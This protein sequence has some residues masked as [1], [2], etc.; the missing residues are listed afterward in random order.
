LA[1]HETT[2]LSR[3][4]LL[5]SAVTA[6]AVLGGAGL[7]AACG[8]S[9]APA[10]V[11]TTAATTAPVAAAATKPATVATTA[12]TGAQAAPTTASAAGATVAPTTG[13]SAAAAPATTAGTTAPTPLPPPAGKKAVMLRLHAR[14]GVEDQ[15]L[16]K[17]LALFQQA[18]PGVGVT[19]ET[20]AGGEYFQKLQ[21]LAAGGNLGDVAHLFT[22]D[23][24]YQQFFL[25]GIFIPIDDYIN[26]EKFDLNQYYKYSLDSARVDGKLGGLPFKSHPS[27]VGLFYN[28]DLFAQAGL[29]PPTLDM[30]LDEL[31]DAA[32]KMTK[33]GDASTATYGYG[34]LWHDIEYYE[35]I[36]RQFGGD[37]F[38]TDGKKWTG[39]SP[40]AAKAWQQQYDLMN[41]YKVSVNPLQSNPSN[42]DLFLSG[43]LGM[44]RANIGTKAGFTKIDKFK[45]NM[46]LPPK[47]PTGSRGS[48]AETDMMSITKFSKARDESWALL[49]AITSKDAGL[50]LA[51]QTGNR[52]ST[53]GGRPDVY[54]SPEF[55]N[56]PGY[57]KGVQENT[58]LA[59]E[60]VEPYRAPDN[61]R[62]PELGRIVDPILDLLILG[63]EQPNK[64]FLD[65]LGAEAQSVMD[66][67]R[68]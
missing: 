3:R 56:L 41:T 58:K 20:F 68:A 66:K 11:P 6:A 33:A 47:G 57:P 10:A 39:S 17:Q 21:T 63:K 35:C 49:K 40:E 27:R 5:R 9:A 38:S 22:G 12:P 55:L 4:I 62:G 65:K 45:W 52:S 54:N 1:S 15:M 7:L 2:L 64:A 59:M 25:A 18:N 48:F 8:G 16:D 29:K 32:K 14:A 30:T 23:M 51:S 61:F 26:K 67:P 60:T 34:F 28:E 36:V 19:Q 13:T 37:L 24:S 42:G 50:G 43:R 53:A 46:T 44:F 31:T